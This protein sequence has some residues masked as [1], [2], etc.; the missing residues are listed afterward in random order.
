MSDLVYRFVQSLTLR[1]K[2]YFR[3]YAQLYSNSKE[4]N[5][6]KIYNILEQQDEYDESALR[7]ALKEEPF[8]K[9]LSSEK[10]Y[11]LEQILNSLINFHANTSINRKL[12]K[13][14]LY[15]NILSEKGFK[16]KANKTLRQ[17]KT[18]ALKHEE[19]TVVLQLIQMEEEILFSHGILDYV[20]QLENLKKEREAINKKIQELNEL[21]L[22]KAQ[23]RE[24][25]YEFLPHVS[26]IVHHPNI[27]SNPLLHSIDKIKSLK[28]KEVWYY[29]NSIIYYLVRDYEKSLESHIEYLDFYEKNEFL[30]QKN[31]KLPIL[32]NYIYLAAKTKN[33]DH[34]FLGLNKLEQLL[35]EKDIDSAYIYYIK[36][37]RILEYYHKTKDHQA[38]A[39]VL[40]EIASYIEDNTDKFGKTEID[41]VICQ[42][43]RAGIETKQFTDAQ[44]WINLWY[45]TVDIEVSLN[46]VK[47]Y[48]IIVYYELDYINLLEH[49]VS[50]TYKTLR[51]RRRLK[52]LERS[53]LRFC[54]KI[55]KDD[56]SSK[57]IKALQILHNDLLEIKKDPLQ[58]V[59]FE[60]FDFIQWTNDK[61]QSIKVNG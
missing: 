38:T 4:K 59:N 34:F 6:L 26:Q 11:L 39:N 17:A 41:H 58:N 15:I 61:I 51:N 33:S 37:A 28:G 18:L 40:P 2:A 44:Q 5:Y 8:V 50:S 10:H 1:E 19:F 25:Q 53:F 20:Q 12:Q 42:L 14:I 30:F 16:K 7:E 21:R 46:L 47:L 52:K 56:S 54:R 48:S 35:G 45:N 31:Q 27:F 23:A 29:T 32:S 3:R 24:L 57:R 60:D 55:V 22:L 9:Y 49:E 43:I 13:L 36:Y